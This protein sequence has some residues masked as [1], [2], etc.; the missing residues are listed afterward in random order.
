MATQVELADLD[1][2]EFLAALEAKGYFAGKESTKAQLRKFAQRG[3]HPF[4]ILNRGEID[5]EEERRE[6]MLESFD[7]PGIARYVAEHTCK[8]IVVICGAGISTSAGIPDFRTPGSGLY[9]N[10]QRFNLPKPQSMFDLEYFR[11]YPAAFYELAREL[12]PGTYNPTPAHHFLR[13]LSDKGVLLRCYSQNIDSLE[14]QAGLPAE[15]L[16]AAHGNFDAAHVID[17]DPEVE[18]DVAVLK[19]ALDKGERGWQMLSRAYGN[20]VKPKI[21]FFGEELPRRFSELH[22]RDLLSCDLLLVMGTSLAV[23]PVA[24][25]VAKASRSAPRVLINQEAVGTCDVSKG[26]FRFHLEGEDNWRDVWWQGDCDSGCR[27]LADVLGWGED[28]EALI[29][30]G[31]TT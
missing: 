2:E 21:V 7:F 5:A 3:V 1:A 11:E 6:R 31:R 9:D 30:A 23:Q 17:T 15:K 12:W 14:C 8:R 27:E 20:L 29:E 25:L 4:D 28:L 16:V 22:T 24:G 18:V 10:L 13:L 19:G 26:G